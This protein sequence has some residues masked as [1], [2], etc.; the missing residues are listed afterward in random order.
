MLTNCR[1]CKVHETLTHRTEEQDHL[2][3]SRD[4]KLLLRS[5][6]CKVLLVAQV[7]MSH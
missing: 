3:R 6:V 4:G 5:V 7:K 1:R 2:L